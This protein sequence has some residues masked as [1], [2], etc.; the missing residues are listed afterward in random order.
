MPRLYTHRP[1]LHACKFRCQISTYTSSDIHCTFSQRFVFRTWG[2]IKVIIINHIPHNYRRKIILSI[3]MMLQACR[4]NVL[5]VKRLVVVSLGDNHSEMNTT[6]PWFNTPIKLIVL[7]YPILEVRYLG[8]KPRPSP[9][10]CSPISC[11]LPCRPLRAE[12][13]MFYISRSSD[14]EHIGKPGVE[15]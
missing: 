11:P 2:M 3:R 4:P 15:T 10:N 9:S 1:M 8:L 7:S 12:T 6:N 13:H 14:P 5:L